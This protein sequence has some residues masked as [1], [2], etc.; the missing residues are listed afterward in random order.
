[1]LSTEA[2]KQAFFARVSNGLLT[3]ERGNERDVNTVALIFSQAP[4]VDVV[5]W[6]D[7][8]RQQHQQ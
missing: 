2:V 8:Y 7:E 4:L 3:D 6:L 1:M 5:E